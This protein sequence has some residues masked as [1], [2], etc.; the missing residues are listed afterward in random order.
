[1]KHFVRLIVAG[2]ALTLGACTTGQLNV[3]PPLH[4]TPVSAV[5]Q[6]SVGTVN[7]NGNPGLNVLATDRAPSG[8]TAIPD[9][10][11]TLTGPG[12]FAGPAGSADP[13]S[14]S[15]SVALGSAVN[16]FPLAS[17]ST[18]F[19]AADG[20]GLGPPGSS[21]SA[22][23]AFPAQP[24][25]GDTVPIGGTF[26]AQRALYGNPPAY[27]AASGSAGYPEGFYLVAL[28]APPPTGTYTL[29]V[30]FSQNGN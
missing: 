12:G 10:T 18:I 21:S 26:S 3:T 27:P 22:V 17:G 14:G 11:A 20:Y 4:F 23:S 30:S 29:T 1:L 5:L 19:A 9:N 2:V 24:Q 25:F 6:M 28:T 16:A 7:F 15:A 13:G 8:F